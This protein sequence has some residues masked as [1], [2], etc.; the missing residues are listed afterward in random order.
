MEEGRHAH[1]LAR[2]QS[3]CLNSFAPYD[4]KRA[5]SSRKRLLIASPAGAPTLRDTQVQRNAA[6]DNS[7]ESELLDIRA[8]V[9]SRRASSGNSV[10]RDVATSSLLGNR[11]RG[12]LD[13]LALGEAGGPIGSTVNRLY[14]RGGARGDESVMQQDDTRMQDLSAMGRRRG[15]VEKGKIVSGR[16]PCLS[17]WI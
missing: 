12:L 14:T 9:I 5:D 4:V 2:V 8:L 3:E 13:G 16:E 17:I 7:K 11:G 10:N 1:K 15:R 6:N